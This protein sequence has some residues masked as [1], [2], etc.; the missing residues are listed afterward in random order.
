MR[1]GG[2]K[3]KEQAATCCFE[4][5]SCCYNQNLGAEVQHV[6]MR[7]REN[8]RDPKKVGKFLVEKEIILSETVKIWR[9][10][11]GGKM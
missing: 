6:F 2:G 1:R 8:N 11:E 10:L 9:E 7:Q 4:D 5:C 3:G